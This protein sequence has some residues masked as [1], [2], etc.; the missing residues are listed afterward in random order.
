MMD[1]FT[2]PHFATDDELYSKANEELLLPIPATP[3][4]LFP[5][6][7]STI[8]GLRPREFSILCGATG[9]GKTTLMA[10]L[11]HSLIL[12]D[13]PHFVASVETGPTDFIKRVMSSM[14]GKDWN[15]GDSVALGDLRA[16]N[17]VFGPRLRKGNLNLSLYEDRFS[18]EQL[19]S[20]ITWM[21]THKKIKVAIIDNLNF[22]MEIT[23]ASNQVIE[24]DR[25]V[26]SLIILC[27]QI[28]VHVVMIM[29][30]RKTDGTRVES[31]FDIKGSSTA[32]QEAH[33]IFLWNRPSK[34]MMDEGFSKTSRE[35]KIAKLRR[36]G[37]AIGVKILFTTNNGVS[38]Q[39]GGF[40]GH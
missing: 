2:K 32:V 30:P 24:M 38:Y 16:F 25:V 9:S 31:E 39:E 15:H 35:L 13:I 37:R 23:S 19:C 5:S 12:D 40:L 26:H 18:V 14:G 1:D 22:F 36:R 10:N 7:N 4:T 29:H 27:K 33:N 20:D 3:V 28:D 34:E 17:G 11:S 6:L 21:V 8:G